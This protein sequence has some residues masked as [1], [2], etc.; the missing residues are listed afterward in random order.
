MHFSAIATVRTILVS[1]EVQ[2]RYIPRTLQYLAS[3][4][5]YATLTQLYV[6]L[7]LDSINLWYT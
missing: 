2:E 1:F 7:F 5:F 6:S 4:C 3:R